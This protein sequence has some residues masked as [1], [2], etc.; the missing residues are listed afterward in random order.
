M[1]IVNENIISIDGSYGEGGGSIVRFSMAF[2]VLLKKA[3]V[4]KNIRS[5]R[6]N[7]GLKTQHLVGINLLHQIFGGT[8]QGAEIGSTSI[9]YYPDMDFKFKKKFYSVTINTAASIGLIIQ[10]LQLI[11]VKLNDEI[12]IEMIGGGTYGLWAPSIDYI[13]HVTS[14]Y[15]KF[16]GCNFEIK[17]DN[18]GFYPKGG[19]KIYLILKPGYSNVK[20]FLDFTKRDQNPSINGISIASNH[21]LRSNVA[22]RA[23]KAAEKI[24]SQHGFDSNIE[25]KYVDSDSI[26]SG[27]TLWTNS[28][29]PFGSSYVG[30][31]GISSEKIGEYVAMN[32]I[33]D[34]NNGGVL[35]EYMTDQ[36]IP[37]MVLY[38]SEIITG[39]LSKHS[40][41]NIW[42]SN[43]FLPT[44]FEIKNLQ[45]SLF[46]IKTKLIKFIF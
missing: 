37:F 39:P 43:Q 24:L 5:K 28:Q 7:P 16:F 18:H 35:D 31:K 14:K 29:Y 33:N 2:A 30:Q 11:L 40:N 6:K 13:E 20:N 27:I 45:K 21:L 8:L 1:T 44:I 38:P 46:S 22:D 3:I 26:G 15:L 17:V 12:T 4:I 25:V 34:W 10:S 41:T 32:F 19:S 23:A 42:I 36:I 9:H